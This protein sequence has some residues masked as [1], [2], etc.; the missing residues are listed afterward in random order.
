MRDNV[1]LLLTV[2]AAGE[3]TW[4]SIYFSEAI[5]HLLKIFWLIVSLSMNVAVFVL[6]FNML[7]SI[8]S[9]N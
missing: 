1:N 7:F 3:T 2:P 8:D 9:S 6:L 5:F 4:I